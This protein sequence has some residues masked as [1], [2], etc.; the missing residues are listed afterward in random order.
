MAPTRFRR[1][2]LRAGASFRIPARGI[3]GADHPHVICSP[4]PDIEIPDANFNDYI[5][6]VSSAAVEKH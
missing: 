2:L 5:T 6:Q 1:L 4:T 3:T